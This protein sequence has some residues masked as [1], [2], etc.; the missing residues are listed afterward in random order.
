MSTVRQFDIPGV[1]FS[2][3][4]PQ[5]GEAFPDIRLPDQTG[6]EIDLHE[7]RAGRPALFVVHRSADW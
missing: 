5:I 7:H 1:D 4:G 3:I 2:T 6:R